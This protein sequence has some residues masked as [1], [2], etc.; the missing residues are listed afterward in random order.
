M[1]EYIVVFITVPDKDKTAEELALKIVENKL[2]ACV[3]II[4]S[5]NSVFFWQGKVE[6][7]KEKLLI[8]KTKRS[9][10]NKLKSFVEENH[11]YQVPEIIGLPILIG[12]EEYLKWIEETV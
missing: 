4:P 1:T 12:N 3:N 8:I 10:F 2:G 7:E 9:L 5:V 11:P 6:E